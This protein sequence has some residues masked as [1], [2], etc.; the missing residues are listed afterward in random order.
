MGDL[1]RRRLGTVIVLGLLVV[2]FSANRIAVLVTDF[3]WFDERG[4]RQVFTTVLTNRVM[5]GVGFGLVLAVLI[6]V[7]L[8]IARKLRPFYVPSSPQQAQIQ[9]YREMADPY[10]PWLIAVIAVV[11]GATTGLALSASW[12]PWLLF[13]NGGEVGV[14]DPQ[15]GV[16]VGFYLFQ[17]PFLQLLQTW[18][19]TSLVLTGLLTA[20]AHYMLGGIRPEAEGEKILP[21]VKAHLAIL[22]AAILAVWAWGYWLNRYELNFSPRGTVT[23]ASYTDVNAELPALYLL[24]GVTVIAI[25]LVLWSIRRSGFLLPGA[26]IALLVVASLILQAAYPAAIQ[27]L[28]VDPQELAREQEFIARNIEATRD[29][30]GLADVEVQP[31]PIENDLDRDDVEE[32][33][34][35]LLNVRLW[36]PEV[37]E[38]TY[39]ELQSLRPYYEFNDVAIDRYE[40]DGE[41]RQVMLSTRELSELPETSDTWQNRHITFTHGYGVVASQVNTANVEGQPVFISANIPPDGQEAVAP[42]A[43][44]G[45]YFGE[46]GEPVYNLVRTEA[47][48][49]D[50]EEPDGQGQVLTEYDGQAGVA[51]NSL[52]RRLAFA[53]RFND[54]N[55]VLTNLLRDDSAIIYNRQISERVQEVAP[56]LELDD[57]PYPVVENGRVKWIV[58]AYTTSNQYP[59]SE[60]A[61][62]STDAGDIPVNYVRNSV[63]AVVD[64][65]DG[66]VTLYRV[67]DDD[68]VLDAWEEIFPGLITPAEEAGDISKNFRYPQD[69]FRLQSDLY[70][71]YHIQDAAEFYNR[72][73]EWDVP[74][75]PAFAANQADGASEL[76][77]APQRRLEP[78][79]LL[80]RLPGEEAEEFVLIQPYL[81]RQRPNMVAWLAGRSDGENLNEL[82]AVRFPTDQQVLG[83]FQAQARIQQDDDISA[84]IT[85]RSREGSQVIF[86]NLQV[87]PIA[88]SILYVQP[89]FLQNPQAQIPEL[90]RV[91]VVMGSRT[92]F[93]RT[94]AGAVSQIIGTDVPDSLIA[95]EAVDDPLDID[96]LEDEDLEEADPD[97]D[98]EADVDTDDPVQVSEELLRDALQAFARADDSLSNGDLA[99]YQRNV[100]AAQDLLEQAAAAQG[101]SLDDLLNGNGEAADADLLDDLDSGDGTAADD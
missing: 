7:N 90:A 78:Y 10:L 51:I 76:T 54:Y 18:A 64:A 48:E 65:Y 21:S 31:L 25:A 96:P 101:I 82:F 74:G 40:I 45:V 46:F 86:G 71:A 12:E 89:L 85:L 75:D 24:M 16:D 84:Y 60:R 92:A 35:T 44:P 8:L 100:R 95:A 33:E 9:R 91:A 66:D 88:D 22:L 11:F 56:F 67:E 5:L 55:L 59:Y 15:F 83:P 39:Q 20:G 98:P 80:M 47:S 23:G 14:T 99:G 79:Y 43:Q 87:L 4:F 57:S 41:L 1:V 30:Y 53:L 27:R 61:L 81:A 34:L 73:D 68:P 72:A 97:A 70:Q 28:R 93:D 38:T 62:L 2:L 50:Y 6:A 69:L 37:L 32:N 17:L 29:A 52:L 42:T 26:A 49:L 94:L 63:K 58:D 3:W 36:D 19:T 13:L 77:Q